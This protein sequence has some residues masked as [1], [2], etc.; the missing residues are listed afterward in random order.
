MPVLLASRVA[1]P[2]KLIS[3]ANA[4]LLLV[5]L[6]VEPKKTFPAPVWVKG[7]A[8]VILAA[9]AMV[10]KPLF[11]IDS[12]PPFVVVTGLLKFITAALMLIPAAPVVLTAPKKFVV[13][14][15]PDTAIDCAVIAGN[16]ALVAL[17]TDTGPR[18]VVCPAAPA[19]LMLP[20]PAAITNPPGPLRVL[21]KVMLPP[22]PAFKVK[23]PVKVTGAANVIGCA[24]VV[25]LPCTEAAPAPF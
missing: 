11:T 12:G 13:P 8:S 16:V 17:V 3:D 6:I 9:G 1:G 22:A 10:S 19:K 14:V 4:M 18:A 5:A 23:L 7:P 21:L 25:M 20:V 24:V 2:I 15:T